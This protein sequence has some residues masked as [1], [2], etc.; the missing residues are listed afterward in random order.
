[1]CKAKVVT[2]PTAR[3]QELGFT[4]HES[5]PCQ[6]TLLHTLCPSQTQMDLVS[7]TL[8]DY[9]GRRH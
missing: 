4:S 1:M 2:K 3:N 7:P 5:T 6:Q 8:R 9:W